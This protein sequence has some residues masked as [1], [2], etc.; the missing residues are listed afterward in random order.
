MK[1]EVPRSGRLEVVR[2]PVNPGREWDDA[3]RAAGPDTSAR[4]AEM[5][6]VAAHYQPQEGEIVHKDIILVNFSETDVYGS[7]F[8][9]KWGI[10]HKLR[11]ASPRELFAIGEHAPDF[12]KHVGMPYMAIH[13]LEECLFRGQRRICAVWWWEHERRVHLS[14]FESGFQ[15]H[16]NKH[17]WTAFVEI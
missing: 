6:Q 12:N 2:I 1:I 3:I 15:N 9:V 13:S 8:V 10:R 4:Y 16:W 14:F 5:R 17:D 7:E 11:N